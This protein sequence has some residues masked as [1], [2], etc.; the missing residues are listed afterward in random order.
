MGHEPT[1]QIATTRSE[2][3]YATPNPIQNMLYKV[4]WNIAPERRDETQARFLETGAPPPDG[5]KM[6]G[7]WHSADTRT[8]VC[9]AETD[10]PVALGKWVQTWSD[11]M[12]LDVHLVLDDEQAAA[13]MQ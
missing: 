1:A 3:D 5:V 11:V 10:D 13:V 12:R 4:Q 6:L 8:G 9:I 2:V 7:R